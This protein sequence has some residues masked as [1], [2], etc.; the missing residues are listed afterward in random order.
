MAWNCCPVPSGMA[1]VAGCTTSDTIVG[2]PT[3]RVVDPVCVPSTALIVAAPMP[4]LVASP[5]CP[6][7]LLITAT[8]A[9]V[10]LHSTLV[11]TSC[12]LPSV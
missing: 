5:A 11:V 12:V 10:E 3:V 7:T 4:E 1:V 6:A 2:S 8:V 9:A